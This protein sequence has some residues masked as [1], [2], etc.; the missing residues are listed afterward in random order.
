MKHFL[1]VLAFEKS[2]R[3]SI[4][5]RR[6]E[7]IN[8][9]WQNKCNSMMCLFNSIS[10]LFDPLIV[11]R[12][13]VGTE[14]MRVGKGGRAH[15]LTNNGLS[16]FHPNVLI[17]RTGLANKPPGSSS[18]HSQVVSLLSITWKQRTEVMYLYTYFTVLIVKQIIS[19]QLR[20]KTIIWDSLYWTRYC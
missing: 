13:G 2:R 3:K 14:G 1:S 6:D 15:H 8:I 16:W 18:F 4:L 9:K 10:L 17:E 11:T 7:V 19:G 12:G 20:A 5:K